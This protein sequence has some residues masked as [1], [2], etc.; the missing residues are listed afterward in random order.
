MSKPAA[1]DIRLGLPV[2][3]SFLPYSCTLALLGHVPAVLKMLQSAPAA[4]FLRMTCTC[5]QVQVSIVWLATSRMHLAVNTTPSVG[6]QH[7]A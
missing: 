1:I 6:T 4:A 5:T 2:A 3:M 7:Q